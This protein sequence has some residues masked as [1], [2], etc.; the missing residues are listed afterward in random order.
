M[1]EALHRVHAHEN[2]QSETEE[3]GEGYEQLEELKEG[4]LTKKPLSFVGL[5]SLS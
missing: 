2:E 4:M 1:Q 5:I 3:H